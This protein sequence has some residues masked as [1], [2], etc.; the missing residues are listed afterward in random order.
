MN[1][2]TKTTEN[3]QTVY[4]F[5]LGMVQ[6]RLAQQE[7]ESWLCFRKAPARQEWTTPT[8]MTPQELQ[9]LVEYAQ[10]H[11]TNG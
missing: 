5:Q 4:Y 6:C 3:G 8:D 7:D 2:V 9:S 11:L 10:S 1:N